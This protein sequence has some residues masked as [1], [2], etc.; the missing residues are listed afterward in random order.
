MSTAAVFDALAPSYD[1]DFTGG[2]IGRLLRQVVWERLD[3][4]FPRAGRVL[5]LGCGTGEDAVHL[6]SSGMRVVAVD[7]SPAMLAR[8]RSKAVASGVG[9]SMRMVELS[10]ERLDELDEQE[11]FDAVLSNFGA[12]N[13]VADLTALGRS[14]ARRTTS[15][16]RLAFCVMGPVVPWEWVW[17]LAQGKPNEALRRLR[18]GGI[19]WHGITVRYPTPAVVARAFAAFRVTRTS[20]LGALI[21]P[22]Y[23][24]RW[25]STHPRLLASLARWE[26]RLE[27]VPPLPWLAD[28]YLIEM[29]AR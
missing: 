20:A 17:Q 21:P 14:V 11:P 13:C 12:L 25:A 10:L 29:V 23:A 18:R 16:A 7:A 26:R 19:R 8:A 6:A 24:E 15:A 28:H 27:A 4:I 9:Q 2:L 5:D 1:A 3:S 22:P